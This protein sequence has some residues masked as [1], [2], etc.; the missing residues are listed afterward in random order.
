[1]LFSKITLFGSQVIKNS[2]QKQN[3]SYLSKH[4]FILFGELENNKQNRE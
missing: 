2:F 3:I 1:M 4:A